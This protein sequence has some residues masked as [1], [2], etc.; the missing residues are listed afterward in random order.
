MSVE[1]LIGIPYEKS[2][3]PKEIEDLKKEVLQLPAANCQLIPQSLYFI[4][5][6]E[7]P[8]IHILSMEVYDGVGGFEQIT[9]FEASKLDRNLRSGDLIVSQRT[10]RIISGKLFTPQELTTEKTKKQLHLA[11][12]IGGK[13]DPLM[14]NGMEKFLK[15]PNEQYIFHTCQFKDQQ[16]GLWTTDE[17]LDHYK[18]VLACRIVT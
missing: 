2:A 4:Y 3:G 14:F 8:P 6:I 10:R 1:R 11:V 15:D 16:S 18:P 5:D 7:I 9:I 17:F 12:W 13:K